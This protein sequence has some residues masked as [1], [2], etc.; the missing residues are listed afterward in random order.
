ME[1]GWGWGTSRYIRFRAYKRTRMRQRKRQAGLALEYVV[2]SLIIYQVAGSGRSFFCFFCFPISNNPSLGVHSGP[3][4]GYPLV[5][6]G[7]M[8]VGKAVTF[9]L[10]HLVVNDVFLF[11]FFFFLCC[12]FLLFLFFWW[13]GYLELKFDM[14]DKL[15]ICSKSCIHQCAVSKEVQLTYLH[16]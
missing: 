10:G 9:C 4:L 8:C 2:S 1:P 14:F 16:T 3:R 7:C 11:F 15:C 6:L 12:F 13:R 5:L